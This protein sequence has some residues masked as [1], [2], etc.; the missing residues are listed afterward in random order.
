MK[1]KVDLYQKEHSFVFDFGQSL[2]ELLAPKS[3]DRILDLGCGTGELTATI[4]N[5]CKDVVGIDKSPEMIEKARTTFKDID[6]V[7]GDAVDFKADHKFTAIF[8][9]ATLHWIKAHK[10]AIKSMW[11]SLENGGRLVL[12]FGGKGNVQTV[13]NGIK[14]ELRSRGYEALVERQPWYFPS[15]GEYTTA[16]EAEGFQVSYAIHYDRP[17]LLSDSNK[18]L[19]NWILMFG[20]PFFKNMNTGEIAEIAEQVQA[21]L[22]TSLYKEGNWYADYK[23]IRILARKTE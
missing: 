21:N 5:Y 11:N 9:N 17:T 8:S 15:I 14:K 12:E 7:V 4:K 2:V 23:R 22:K 1:W 18:G 10:A 20:M 16:L 3:N 6:F 19:K 13:V